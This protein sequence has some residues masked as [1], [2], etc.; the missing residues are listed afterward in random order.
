MQRHPIVSLDPPILLRRH[1]NQPIAS[2]AG[3]GD[4][5]TEGLFRDS[6]IL[7][8]ELAGGDGDVWHAISLSSF[9]YS[10]SDWLDGAPYFSHRA[11]C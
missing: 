7:A 8:Q 4:G 11:L 9:L 10:A 1:Q 5:F 6:A 2:V 3:D